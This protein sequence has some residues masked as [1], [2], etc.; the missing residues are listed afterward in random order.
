MKIEIKK[1]FPDTFHYCKLLVNGIQIGE[2]I[3]GEDKKY[4]NPEKWA[5]DQLNKRNKVLDKNIMRL[6]KELMELKEEKRILN[7]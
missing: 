4:L 3:H 5:R 2:Y 1:V 7:K 6:E